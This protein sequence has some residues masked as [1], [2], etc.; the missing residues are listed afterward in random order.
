MRP[1]YAIKLVVYVLY[2]NFNLNSFTEMKLCL[3]SNDYNWLG[4]SDKV[5]ASECTN[6]TND[7]ERAL[8]KKITKQYVQGN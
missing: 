7:F 6:S 4:G 8:G 1:K 3:Y 2:V 5:V